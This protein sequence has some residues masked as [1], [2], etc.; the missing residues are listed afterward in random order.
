MASITLSAVWLNLAS[1]LSDCVELDTM[2]GLTSTPQNTG[3][4]RRYASG[5]TRAVIPAGVP[6][7]FAVTAQAVPRSTIVWLE[8]H[9]GQLMLIR[10]DRG[11]KFYGTCFQPATAEHQYDQDGDVTVTFTEI[12]YSEAV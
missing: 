10:D 8:S 2:T 7:Q 9:T 11:R 12:S 6:N 3:T 1:D 5:R 4:I